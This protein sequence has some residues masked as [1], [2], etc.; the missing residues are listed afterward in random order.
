MWYAHIFDSTQTMRSCHHSSSLSLPRLSPEVRS[1]RF[2]AKPHTGASASTSATAAP[3]CAYHTFF[4]VAY[5]VPLHAIRHW[6]EI[7]RWENHGCRQGGGRKCL[8]G[9]RRRRTVFRRT[10]RIFVHKARL[11][12][13]CCCD[14]RS[15]GAA[16]DRRGHPLHDG[17]GE[18]S[19]ARL[20]DCFCC[21]SRFNWGGREYERRQLK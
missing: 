12:P 20:D 8:I 17:G 16:R 7:G 21:A 1:Q 2:L 10:R 14:C 11:R 3:A 6:V 18:H 15:C 19:G 5:Q 4:P 9:R 13:C